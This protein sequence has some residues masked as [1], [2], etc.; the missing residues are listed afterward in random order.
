MTADGTGIDVHDALREVIR[1]ARP[2]RTSHSALATATSWHAQN[3]NVQARC[4]NDGLSV[5]HHTSTTQCR[6]QG[7][8][9]ALWLNS[10][11]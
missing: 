5:G 3:F 4:V 2:G 11:S 8:H 9:N 10:V 1:Q 6:L 7:Y